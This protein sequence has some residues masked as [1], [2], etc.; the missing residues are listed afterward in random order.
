MAVILNKKDTDVSVARIDWSDLGIVTTSTWEAI[1]DVTIST[2][3]FDEN[4]VETRVNGGTA[5]STDV[6][7]NTATVNGVA[8]MQRQVIVR[9]H[10]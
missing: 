8:G 10:G 2:Q 9:V 4:T 5:G 6:L 7:L 1:G 3:S